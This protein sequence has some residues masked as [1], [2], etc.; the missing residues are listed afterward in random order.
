MN[1]KSLLTMALMLFLLAGVTACTQAVTEEAPPAEPAIA[2]LTLTGEFDAETS[3]T[4][5]ELQSMDAI[6]VETTNKDGETVQ[7]TGV[8]LLSLLEEAGLQGDAANLTFV[9][10]DG[11][12]AQA[13]V[14][15]I[16]ACADCIVAFNDDGTLSMVL[17]GFSGKVQVKGVIEIR[18]E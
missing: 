12:E 4:L 13:E 5:A 3:W 18:A 15:E 6:T 10:S 9:G 2:A 11:Y 17:P 7:N 1:K 8:K 14:S 16:N